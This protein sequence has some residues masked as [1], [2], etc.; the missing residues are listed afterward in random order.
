[1]TDNIRH[2]QLRVAYCPTELMH[3]D[4][5]TKPLQGALFR[6]HV[7]VIMNL[8][9]DYFQETQETKSADP[10]GPQECVEETVIK[11]C[12]DGSAGFD[13]AVQPSTGKHSLGALL[14][15]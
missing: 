5:F 7:T 15:S 10:T 8:K 12:P 11:N 1:M 13:E 2:K 9:P 6:K 3:A 14:T 4:F